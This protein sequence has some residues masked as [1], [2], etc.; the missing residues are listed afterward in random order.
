MLIFRGVSGIMG[1][2]TGLTGDGRSRVPRHLDPLRRHARSET[3]QAS[4][5]VH[6]HLGLGPLDGGVGSIPSWSPQPLAKKNNKHFSRSLR[7]PA[8]QYHNSWM[9]G[10]LFDEYL[11]ARV[12]TD[13]QSANP[14]LRRP[15]LTSVTE[16]QG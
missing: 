9:P 2:P 13:V 16:G 5:V 3:S 14:S 6:Q 10:C 15:G 1:A 8:L 11:F 12:A 4:M 7:V